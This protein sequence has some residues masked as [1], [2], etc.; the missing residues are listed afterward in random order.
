MLLTYAVATKIGS[1]ELD[2][3]HIIHILGFI[4]PHFFSLCLMI[5]EA[6]A[7]FQA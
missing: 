1:C 2:Q 5:M 6:S 4:T 3:W 7:I